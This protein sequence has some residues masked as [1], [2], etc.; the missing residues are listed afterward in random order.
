MSGP[1]TNRQHIDALTG[2]VDVDLRE[3]RFEPVKESRGWYFVE[4]RPPQADEWFAT[5]NLQALEPATDV[6]VAEAMEGELSVWLARYPMPIML[7]A[8]DEAGDRYELVGIRPFPCLMGYVDACTGKVSAFWKLLSNEDAPRTAPSNGELLEV[9]A[10]VPHKFTSEAARESEFRAYARSVRMGKRIVITWLIIWGAVIPAGVAI[11]EWAAPWWWLGVLVLAY[12]IYRAVRQA[13]KLV[14][15]WKPSRR[16]LEAREKRDRMEVCYEECERNPVG[17]ER[18][19]ME[20]LE[21]EV[22]EQIQTE[23]REL[24]ETAGPQ[25]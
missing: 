2:A 25:A 9:Y 1:P 21:Q 13:L 8:W 4:Y 14:G 3:I 11:L 23:A 18:L 7:C 19:R 16:E 5:L 24:R 20:N 15:L 22:R 10:D 6:A 17:F 12:S